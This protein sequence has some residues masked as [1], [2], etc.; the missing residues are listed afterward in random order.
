MTRD[1]ERPGQQQV[2]LRSLPHLPIQE[3]TMLD[4]LKMGLDHVCVP[5]YLDDLIL[6]SRSFQ[7]HVKELEKIFKRLRDYKFRINR[8]KTH[9][10]CLEVRYLFHIISYQG[11]SIDPKK[12]EAIL[13][14]REPVTIKQMQT[15]M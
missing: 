2:N 14:M 8:G 5:I 4:R 11:I 1:A 15:F 6:L 10:S 12:T 9:F 13:I 7:E 3:V